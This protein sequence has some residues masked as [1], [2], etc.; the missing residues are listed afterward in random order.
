[1]AEQVSGWSTTD[2][3]REL[4]AIAHPVDPADVPYQRLDKREFT[5]A[6]RAQLSLPAVSPEVEAKRLAAPGAR[7]MPGAA[8]P[9]PA[10]PPT[11]PRPA[12]PTYTVEVKALQD[13]LGESDVQSL[14]A[15]QRMASL[16][17]TWMARL[18]PLTEDE[19]KA[20][21]RLIQRNITANPKSRD[22]LNALPGKLGLTDPA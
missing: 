18:R 6:K 1:M 4:I 12:E 14:S 8:A 9:T 10:A 19:R 16:D 13:W 7:P 21:L 20:A 17:E 3:L 22:W 11:P 15:K 2:Q 5:D